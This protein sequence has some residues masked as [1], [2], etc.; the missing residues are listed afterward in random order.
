[1]FAKEEAEEAEE[2]SQLLAPEM[3]PFL[4]VEDNN[5]NKSSSLPLFLLVMVVVVMVVLLLP[6]LSFPFLSFLLTKLGGECGARERRKEAAARELWATVFVCLLVGCGCQE[7]ERETTDPCSFPIW[8]H[9]FFQEC[10]PAVVVV[11]TTCYNCELA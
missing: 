5:K 2:A 1:L 9:I 11:V 7:R 10:S 3:S 6:F 4:L 8:S